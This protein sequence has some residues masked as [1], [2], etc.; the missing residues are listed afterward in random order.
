MRQRRLRTLACF[1]TSMTAFALA[2]SAAWADCV[3]DASGLVVACTGTSTGYTNSAPGV[4]VSVASGTTISG[5]VI[6]GDTGAITNAGTVTG[7]AGTPTLQLG[8][9]G[10]VTNAGTVSSTGATA[11]SAGVAFGDYGTLTNNGSLTALAGTNVAQFGRGGSFANTT[12]A[13]AAVTGNI[14]FGPNIGSDVSTFSNTNAVF[15]ITG[16]ISSSGNT[17]IYNSGLL[18]GNIVQAATGGAVTITNDSGGSYAGSISTGDQTQLVN[19]G[20]MSLGGASS[21]GTARLG[22]SSVSNQGTLTVGTAA[23]PTQL[24]IYGGFS[25]GSSGI[26]NIGLKGSPTG[27]PVAGSTYSQVYATGSNGT[28]V[29]GGTLNIVPAAGF[30]P[31]GSTY[32]VVLADRGITGSFAS[33]TG[34]SLPFITFAPVGIVTISGTQQAYQFTAVRSTT[35]AAAIASVATPNQLVVATAFEPIV[36]TANVTPTGDAATLIGGLDV[37]TVAQAQTFFD[38]VSPE[39]YLAYATAMR[40]QM[41]LFNR[42]VALRLNDQ[43]SRYAEHGWWMNAGGQGGFGKTG[44]YGSKASII[45]VDGGYDFSGPP[46]A[47]TRGHQQ[48]KLAIAII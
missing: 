1:S 15:G 20:T 26:L 22:T 12:N 11:G 24:A 38:Q 21:L 44:A 4:A 29:L 46:Y 48:K 23:V 47:L 42:Q 30:Y 45:T 31:T 8:T 33:V 25:Q 7:T 19:S 43:N 3:P 5:P 32:N 37:M 10:V 14:A 6:A 41:N 2:P 34:N 36:N 28:V 40:D 13:T 18:T 27:L 16:S 39:G 35:Y 17:V 9:N